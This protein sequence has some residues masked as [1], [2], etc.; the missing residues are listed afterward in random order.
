MNSSRKCDS[1]DRLEPN[2]TDHRITGIE[3]LGNTRR[4]SEYM[5]E[6][7]TQQG[8]LN[9]EWD[10]A[11]EEIEVELAN[12]VFLADDDYDEGAQWL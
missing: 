12:S 2:S 7:Q 1:I 11:T 5:E 8:F 9:V 3:K 4:I 10:E 6:I